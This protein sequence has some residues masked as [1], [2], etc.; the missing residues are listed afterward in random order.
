MKTDGMTSLYAAKSVEFQDRAYP[1]HY[2]QN[3]L[4][5]RA[6]PRP[7]ATTRCCCSFRRAAHAL[8][9]DELIGNQ[10]IVVKNA[11]PPFAAFQVLTARRCWLT[12]RSC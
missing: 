8:Q 5:A 12:A 6:R 11:W 7:R 4:G 2:L 3:L 9:I 1:L 10:E